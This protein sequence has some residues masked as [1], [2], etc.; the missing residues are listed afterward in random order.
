MT[1]EKT[2]APAAHW[3]R[4]TKPSPLSP[5]QAARQG[6]ITSFAFLSLGRDA[7]IAFLNSDDAELGGQPLLLATESTA[8]ASKVRAKLHRLAAN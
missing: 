2:R 1:E 6:D 3:R 8:G 5:D 4:R 7:A